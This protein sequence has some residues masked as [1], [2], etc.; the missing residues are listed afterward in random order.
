MLHKPLPHFL[1]IG[2]GSIGQLYFYHINKSKLF[3]VNFCDPRIS[4]TKH[5]AS[6]IN[7]HSKTSIVSKKSYFFAKILPHKKIKSADIILITTKAYQVKNVCLKIKPLLKQSTIIIILVNGL[8]AQEEAQKILCNNIVLSASTTNGA[9]RKN[10]YLH[11][12]GIGKTFIEYKP[13]ISKKLLNYLCK[14]IPNSVLTN[15]INEILLKKLTINS[16][17]NPL[18]VKYKCKNGELLNHLDDLKLLSNE[19]YNLLLKLK[20][21]TKYQELFDETLE[22]IHKTKENYSSMYQ[23]YAYNR[24][25]ELENILGYVIKKSKQFNTKIPNIEKLYNNIKKD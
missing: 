24:K 13:G 12:T 25:S 9:Y 8:G 14:S 21:Q 19:L 3:N 18:T 11:F 5:L 22:V 1:I 17:I 7:Y 10:N 23:D 6:K 4:F 2:A 20:I 15:N 16:L